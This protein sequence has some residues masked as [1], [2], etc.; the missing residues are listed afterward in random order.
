MIF[1]LQL[2]VLLIYL[3]SLIKLER[4]DIFFSVYQVMKREKTSAHFYINR[5]AAH[6]VCGC[7]FLVIT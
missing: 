5:F 4:N 2:K 7:F 6:T 3:L 1:F